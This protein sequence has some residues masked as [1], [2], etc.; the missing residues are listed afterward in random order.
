MSIYQFSALD[1][2]NEEKSLGDYKDKV[3]LI[4]NTASK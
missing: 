2:D 4:V 3:V 1:M